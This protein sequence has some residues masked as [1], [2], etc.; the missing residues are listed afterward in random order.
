MFVWFAFAA[1]LLVTLLAL[2]RPLL[3]PSGG[4]AEGEDADVYAAQLDEVEADRERG[5]IGAEEAAAARTE[6]ARRLLRVSRSVSDGP[7]AGRRSWVVAG[8]V[9]IFLPVF[10]F[11]AYFAVGSPSYGDQPLALREPVSPQGEGDLMAMLAAAEEKL[12][13]NPDDGRG[14]AAVAPV[15]LRIGR[16]DDAADAYARANALLGENASFLTGE[17]QALM[18]ANEGR[19]TDTA[20]TRLERAHAI[21]PDAAAPM[22]F[23]AIGE[24]EAGDIE[25]AAARWR[26]LLASSD[27]TEPWLPIARAEIAQLPGADIALPNAP[28]GPSAADIEAAAGLS[29]EQR[30]AMI[31]GMVTGLATRLDTEGGTPQEWL[32]LVRTYRV[33]GR[34]AD[35]QDAA[36]RA[37]EALPEAERAA[38]AE[39]VEANEGVD[40]MGGAQ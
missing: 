39:A 15:F 28:R 7:R 38:F 13:A 20:R 25:G 14:W 19:M 37:L 29:D 36:A 12:A 26:T 4:Q 9:A 21:E 18:L 16:F 24:R 27:G 1:I 8:L 11:A 2:A 34:E 40:P 35:A 32:R 33:L 3:G 31:E 6:I 5:L 10:S 30:G 17:A 23:L 22:I